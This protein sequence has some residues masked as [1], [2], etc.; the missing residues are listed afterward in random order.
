MGDPPMSVQIVDGRR[1][2]F[3]LVPEMAQAE[4]AMSAQQIAGVARGM[5]VI[6]VPMA[7]VAR[8]I[9]L[10]DRATKLLAGQHHVATGYG[11]TAPF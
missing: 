6:D 7:V 11:Q 3:G 9:G 8:L 1:Q 10:T 2:H 5:I 4:I